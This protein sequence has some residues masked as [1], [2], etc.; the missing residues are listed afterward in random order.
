MDLQQVAEE[1]P[2]LGQT[3]FEQPIAQMLHRNAAAEIRKDVDA[4]GFRA[5]RPHH[6]AV[7]RA[8]NAEK[9]VRAGVAQLDNSLNLGLQAAQVAP[10]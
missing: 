7:P 4:R 2:L 8:V 6:H 10:D 1:L 3:R 9:I 5:K